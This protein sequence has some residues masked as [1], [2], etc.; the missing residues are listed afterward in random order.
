MDNDFTYI[1]FCHNSFSCFLTSMKIFQAL[2]T[3]KHTNKNIFEIFLLYVAECIS[4]MLQCRVFPAPNSA[5]IHTQLCFK[6]CCLLGNSEPI[7]TCQFSSPASLLL[8]QLVSLFLQRRGI[9]FPI[10]P[11]AGPVA[12]NICLANIRENISPLSNRHW[13]ATMWRSTVVS[14][15]TQQTSSLWHTPLTLSVTQRNGLLTGCLN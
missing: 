2:Y 12:T 1:V 10:S 14:I 9:Y 4:V 13:L 11:V 6:T 5:N 8:F 7:I 15:A 3:K